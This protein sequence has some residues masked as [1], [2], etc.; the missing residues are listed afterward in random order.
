MKFTTQNRETDILSYQ[1]LEGI[2]LSI[3][4]VL[5]LDGENSSLGSI[6]NCKLK[7]PLSCRSAVFSKHPE[8]SPLHPQILLHSFGNRS[9]LNMI[10]Q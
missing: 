10:R 7:S 9:V 1:D 2:S 4:L 5:S 6:G 8:Y 3:K